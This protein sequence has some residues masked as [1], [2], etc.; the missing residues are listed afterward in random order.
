MVRDLSG[1][2]SAIIPCNLAYLACII[3]INQIRRMPWQ[4]PQPLINR[5]DTRTAVPGAG[6]RQ[7][8]RDSTNRWSL[9]G[10]QSE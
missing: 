4:H 10:E 3:D 5:P 1:L 9:L 2:N 8:E 6:K 7:L